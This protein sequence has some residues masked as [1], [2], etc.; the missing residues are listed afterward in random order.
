MPGPSEEAWG[1]LNTGREKKKEK[2][3]E[4]KKVN[5]ILSIAAILVGHPGVRGASTSP[6]ALGSSAPAQHPL[7]IPLPWMCGS[8]HCNA[9]LELQGWPRLSKR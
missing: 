6:A 2:G 5:K 4:K 8:A 7:Q 1:S 3:K 9:W